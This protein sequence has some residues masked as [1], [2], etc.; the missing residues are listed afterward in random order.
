MKF[1]WSASMMIFVGSIVL[2]FVGSLGFLGLVKGE[3]GGAFAFVIISMIGTGMFVGGLL[4]NHD[5]HF[6]EQEQ[7][8]VKVTQMR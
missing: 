2:A 6:A 1:H 4:L 3:G 7:E 5:N 8:Q